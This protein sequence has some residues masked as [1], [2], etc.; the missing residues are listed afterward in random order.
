MCQ[1]SRK[2][3]VQTQTKLRIILAFIASDRLSLLVATAL[4]IHTAAIGKTK[5][6]PQNASIQLLSFTIEQTMNSKVL[7]EKTTTTGSQKSIGSV[8]A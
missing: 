8:G 2:A 1:A 6:I 5:L 7:A 3:Q 4:A